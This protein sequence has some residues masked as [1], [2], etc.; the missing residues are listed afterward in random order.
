MKRS[1]GEF[2]WEKLINWGIA[3][4]YFTT[5][6]ELCYGHIREIPVNMGSAI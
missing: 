5:G 4:L 2:H 6:I 1:N 3:Y